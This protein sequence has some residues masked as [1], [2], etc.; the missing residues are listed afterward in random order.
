MMIMN[1]LIILILLI[2][3]PT[4]SYAEA[5]NQKT[6]LVYFRSDCAPC[7]REMKILPEIAQ[8]HEEL[9]IN[10]VSLNGEGM[11]F[12][13]PVFPG[14]VHRMIPGE[15][16]KQ[17]IRNAQ[18]KQIML[19]FSAFLRTD[20]SVCGTHTGILGTDQVKQWADKC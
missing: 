1:R 17:I 16:E 9:T 5:G 8:E 7:M 19:P 3:L 15:R 4:L 20:G 6:L 18:G 10:I 2:F 11:H 12:V 13:P 14:N